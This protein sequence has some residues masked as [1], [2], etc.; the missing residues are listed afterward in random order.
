MSIFDVEIAEIGHHVQAGASARPF[1]L[2]SSRT[3]SQRRHDLI[4]EQIDR[5]LV[6]GAE[7]GEGN[8][9]V[10]EAARR[11]D[12]FDNL[13]SD[14]FGCPRGIVSFDHVFGYEFGCLFDCGSRCECF[15]EPQHLLAFNSHLRVLSGV[16]PSASHCKIE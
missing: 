16:K 15:F 4:G 9:I 2:K 5:F 6:I 1:F 7:L 3:L 14:F 12:E 8:V 13:I 11:S 10:A